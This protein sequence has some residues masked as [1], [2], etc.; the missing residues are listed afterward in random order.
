MQQNF[1]N[2]SEHSICTLVQET[3]PS[4]SSLYETSRQ[5]HHS[6]RIITLPQSASISRR[7]SLWNCFNIPSATVLHPN[8]VQDHCSPFIATLCISSTSPTTKQHSFLG[9]PPAC[10]SES[11][12]PMIWQKMYLLQDQ[13]P[14]HFC[15]AAPQ[16]L[17]C[18]YPAWKIGRRRPTVWCLL[19]LLNV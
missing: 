14:P 5:T 10:V 8:L 3:L 7:E 1:R 17:T 2:T 12:Q 19:S 4:S 6:S 13:A 18:A 9:K 11:V 15:L 16:F